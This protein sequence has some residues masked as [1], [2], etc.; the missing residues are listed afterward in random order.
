MYLPKLKEGDNSH[1]SI[2]FAELQ[3]MGSIKLAGVQLFIAVC[4]VP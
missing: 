3:V 4:S 2:V 1:G